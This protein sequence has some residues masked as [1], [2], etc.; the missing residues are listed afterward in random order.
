MDLDAGLTDD[1]I[2]AVEF[3][4]GLTD[5]E[6]VAVECKFAFRFPPDLRAFLQTALPAAQNF[7]IGG[8]A[9]RRRFETGST[10]HGTAFYSTSN[11]T[12]SGSTSGVPSLIRS[13]RHCRLAA[14]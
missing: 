1:E 14:I 9:T 2:A 8:A 12:A 13:R 3:D 4:A 11:T 7:L 6:I 5:A 10:F